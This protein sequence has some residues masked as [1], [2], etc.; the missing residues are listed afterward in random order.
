MT[1]RFTIGRV[2]RGFPLL[3]DAG[4]APDFAVTPE[5]RTNGFDGRGE[6]LEAAGDALFAVVLPGLSTGR[7]TGFEMP[8]V[9][10]ADPFTGNSVR[11][12]LAVVP[13]SSSSALRFGIPGLGLVIV[14]D[15]GAGFSPVIDA[16]KSL[17]C[18]FN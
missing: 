14:V 6:G 16:N 12:A 1:G 10:R 18:A 8:P 4:R 7:D 11:G 13:R 5:G 3:V 15:E 17:I 2:G 9:G